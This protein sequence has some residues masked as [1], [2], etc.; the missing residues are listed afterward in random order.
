MSTTVH[1]PP[2]ILTAIDR[3]SRELNISRN[4]YICM[5]LEKETSSDWPEDFKKKKLSPDKKITEAVDE[6]MEAIRSGLTRKGSIISDM[7]IAIAAHAKR[8]GCTL[9]TDNLSDFRKILGI[10]IVNWKVRP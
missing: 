2:K 8:Y 10:E 9:V 3:K 7:D 4:K 1:I 5:A 6:M